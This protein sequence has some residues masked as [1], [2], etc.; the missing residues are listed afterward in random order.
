[1]TDCGFKSGKSEPVSCDPLRLRNELRN[2]FATSFK[3]EIICPSKT[4]VKY[5]VDDVSCVR[6]SSRPV[7]E[8]QSQGRPQQRMERGKGQSL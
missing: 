6:V 5:P 3:I 4:E 2:D 1:M 7:H 8:R